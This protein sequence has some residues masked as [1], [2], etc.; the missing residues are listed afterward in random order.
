MVEELG[1]E[2][3]VEVL[4]IATRVVASDTFCRLLGSEPEPFLDPQPGR[5]SRERV[6]PRPKKI[7]S[8]IAV[9]NA[10]VPPFTQALVPSEND[11]TNALV[12]TLYM[13]GEEMADPD[14]R[15]GDLHRTQ[16]EMAA[17]TLSYENECFY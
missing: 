17:S 4:G 7:K 13:T 6:D 9:G 3:Y 2:K 14:F 12:E 5:P 1:E 11:A 15:R 16:I 8:W 10:L